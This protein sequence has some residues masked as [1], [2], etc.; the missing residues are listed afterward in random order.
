MG[1]DV[2]APRPDGPLR[3]RV[4]DHSAHLILDSPH[5]RNAISGPLVDALHRGL[6]RAAA[7]PEVRVVVLGHTGGTFCAGA[8]L[9]EAS[10]P[11]D[12]AADGPEA[13]AAERARLFIA[14]LRAI[15][16][17]PKPVVAVV[18]GHV[19]AG[20]MGLVGACDL[21]LAGPSSSFALTEVR[22]GLAPAMITA[23]LLPRLTSRAASRYLLSGE[24]FD[25]GTAERIGLVTEAVPD[26][27]AAA[28]EYLATFAGC[29]PQ[30]LRETK[31]LLTAEM[32]AHLD[33]CGEDLVQRSAR[34]FAS[35]E[36]AEGMTAFLE[37]R[38]PSWAGGSG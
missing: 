19:R 11:A 34:L 28:R 31:E 35:A 17:L 4:A 15:V 29:S 23:T 16:A 30:G 5:N 8:D 3:Y 26:P 9:S 36:A 1:T 37:R 13:A 6:E 22:L 12:G 27:A 18:D 32:L 25:A 24:R 10:G 14:L 20:G 33:A 21:A 38:P 2:N 7:D